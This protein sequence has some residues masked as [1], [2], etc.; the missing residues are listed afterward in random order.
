ML[1][2][3]LRGISSNGSRQN[4]AVLRE[5]LR[6]VVRYACGYKMLSLSRAV[7]LNSNSGF[8]PILTTNFSTFVGILQPPWLSSGTLAS[9]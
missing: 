4:P 5:L 8:K 7:D 1:A 3:G 6:M 9:S 2:I